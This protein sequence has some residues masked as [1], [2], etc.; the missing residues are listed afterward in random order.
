M[1]RRVGRDLLLI[2]NDALNGRRF[3]D[4]RGS[5]GSVWRRR[6]APYILEVYTGNEMN[7]PSN[8]KR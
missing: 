2:T 6:Q 5:L 8:Q 3:Q 4:K 7:V 1:R